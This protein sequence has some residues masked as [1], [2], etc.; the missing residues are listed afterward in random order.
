MSRSTD[1][2]RF[3]RIVAARFWLRIER[4]DDVMLY[5]TFPLWRRLLFWWGVTQALRAV[6]PLVDVC[7]VVSVSA[8]LLCAAV[9][10]WGPF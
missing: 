10:G 9:F 8:L 6:Y 2:I 7:I 5:Q 4:E 3:G 1:T